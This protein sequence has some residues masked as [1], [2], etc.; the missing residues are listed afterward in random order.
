[1]LEMNDGKKV[2]FIEKVVNRG[3]YLFRE[4]ENEENLLTNCYMETGVS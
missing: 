2:F 1:M 4:L 3:E